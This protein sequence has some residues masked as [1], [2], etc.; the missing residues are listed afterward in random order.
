MIHPRRPPQD[1]STKLYSGLLKKRPVLT[2]YP[3]ASIS[4]ALAPLT[5]IFV[6]IITH[7]PVPVFTCPSIA[8]SSSNR[9]SE[10]V[11]VPVLFPFAYRFLVLHRF[12]KLLL[13]LEVPG[14]GMISDFASKLQ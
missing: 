2:I 1:S 5:Y 7:V 3:A 14:L 13:Q 4:L 11:A 9:Q 8:S 6:R 12:T 10:R